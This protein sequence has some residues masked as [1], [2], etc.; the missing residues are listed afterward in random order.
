MPVAELVRALAEV[1]GVSTR[2]EEPL[3]HHLPLR[4]GGPVQLWAV[5]HDMDGLH[6]TVQ[7]ARTHRVN[8]RVHWPFTDWLVRDGGLAGAVFRLGRGFE[9]ITISDDHVNLGAAAL[10]SAVP[11]ELAGPFWDELRRWPGSVG[12]WLERGIDAELP[13]CCTEIS[14]LQG[15]RVQAFPVSEDDGWPALAKTAIPLGITLM[16]R[17]PPRVEILPPPP[18]GALFG[19]VLDSTPGRELE[20]AGVSGTRLR[21]WRLARIEPGSL[22]Q[23]GGGSCKDLMMLVS[24]IRQ[25]VE[26]T[27]GAKLEVR[28]PLLGNEPGRRRG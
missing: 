5:I 26:K 12:G 18:P 3:C 24:G 27:R 17:P 8:W 11:P 10:W 4:V 2:T 6:N 20:R 21:R 25:R 13:L 15:G 9:A 14:V 19:S 22:V 23:L 16:R 1:S 7:A 28:I